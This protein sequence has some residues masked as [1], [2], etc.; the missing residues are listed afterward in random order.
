MKK[1][2]LVLF[3]CGLLAPALSGCAD[4]Y[5]CKDTDFACI[6]QCSID[7]DD[8]ESCARKCSKS[9]DE[10]WDEDDWDDEDD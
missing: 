9:I 7:C 4:E 6:M 10:Q 8:D 3:V 2:M 1:F 5:K